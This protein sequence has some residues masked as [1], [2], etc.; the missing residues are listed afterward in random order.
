MH[1]MKEWK[2][3][4]RNKIKRHAEYMR[5]LMNTINES[6]GLGDLDNIG[7]GGIDSVGI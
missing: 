6:D 3:S 4:N 1:D 5:G 7:L 2:P